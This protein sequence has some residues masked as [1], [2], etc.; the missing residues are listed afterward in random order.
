MEEKLIFTPEDWG[1]SKTQNRSLGNPADF[2]EGGYGGDYS[3]VIGDIGN[4]DF[5]GLDFSGF[6]LDILFPNGV[7]PSNTTVVTTSGIQIPTGTPV[8]STSTGALVTTVPVTTNSGTMPA[9]TVVDIIVPPGDPIGNLPIETE[10]IK[11]SYGM[12]YAV[13]GILAVW[14]LLKKKK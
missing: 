13:G 14:L 5:S 4:I 11:K 7:V 2:Y 8:S 9:G 6:N 10:P 3:D 12:L 1:L